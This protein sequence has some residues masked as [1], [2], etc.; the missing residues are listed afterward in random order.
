MEN[1]DASKFSFFISDSCR[2]SFVLQINDQKSSRSKTAWAEK[3]QKALL[4]S[5]KPVY[6]LCKIKM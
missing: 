2:F 5:Y 1:V 4:L 3:F 6:I